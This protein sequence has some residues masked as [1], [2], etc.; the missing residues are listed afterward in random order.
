MR[1]FFSI[2][3]LCF[4]LVQTNAV[5]QSYKLRPGD[6]LDISV[7]QD[8][9]LNRV[10][11]VRPD[12]QIS[13]PLAGHMRAAGSSLEALEARLKNR[14]RKFYAE[15][16][17]VTVSLTL[18]FKDEKEDEDEEL[19][20]LIYVTGEVNEPGPFEMKK[21]TTVLQALALSGGLGPYA[22]KRRIQIRRRIEGGYELYPFDYKAVEQGNYL[23]DNIYLKDGDVVVVPERRLFE[24]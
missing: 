5:G 22:A 17:D 19:P 9:K 10:V 18:A 1:V 14:L 23:L 15:S 21:P 24:W 7:W 11:V 16:L 6:K 3:L 2:V 12:G 8:D 20:D 13:F 4:L